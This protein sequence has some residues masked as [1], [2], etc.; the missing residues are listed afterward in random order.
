MAI[1]FDCPNLEWILSVLQCPQDSRAEKRGERTGRPRGPPQVR[2]KR[3]SFRLQDVM[4]EHVANSAGSFTF[5]RAQ[6][7]VELQRAREEA[8]EE[9]P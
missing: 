6:H 1:R 5:V 2:L 3:C 4:R 8:S 9:V 7:I